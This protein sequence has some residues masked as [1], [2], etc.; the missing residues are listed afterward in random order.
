MTNIKNRKWFHSQCM[1]NPYWHNIIKKNEYVRNWTKISSLFTQMSMLFCWEILAT[2][3]YWASFLVSLDTHLL[4]WQPYYCLCHY[5]GLPQVD[6]YQPWWIEVDL[7]VSPEL[8]LESHWCRLA[9]SLIH[10]WTSL[11]EVSSSKATKY[12]W[13]FNWILSYLYY[14][15][16]NC[17]K[18]ILTFSNANFNFSWN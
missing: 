11:D 2:K 8:L 4:Y 5:Q 10:P 18:I 3:Q 17:K 13:V 7:F 15:F 12:F 9:E 14:I 6:L 16:L 1:E